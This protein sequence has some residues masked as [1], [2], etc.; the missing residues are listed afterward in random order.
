MG[1]K[2]KSKGRVD[3][4]FQD[5]TTKLADDAINIEQAV[6]GAQRLWQVPKLNGWSGDP[7]D[8][9]GMAKPFD[10]QDVGSNYEEI[11]SDSS[12]PGTFGDIIGVAYQSDY[13]A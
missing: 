3:P 8:I 6:D 9:P 1:S 11:T 12:N 2:G 7:L 13:L 4:L 10:R 5:Q